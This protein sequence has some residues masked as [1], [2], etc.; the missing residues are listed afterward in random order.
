MKPNVNIFKFPKIKHSIP[1]MAITTSKQ[2][3]KL[4]HKIKPVDKV[5]TTDSSIGIRG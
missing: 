5:T 4:I 2:L 3:S 1:D